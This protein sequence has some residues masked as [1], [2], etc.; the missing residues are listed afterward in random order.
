MEPEYTDVVLLK[1]E[2]GTRCATKI[3]LNRTETA[4][5]RVGEKF[6]EVSPSLATIIIYIIR[7]G[8]RLDVWFDG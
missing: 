6:H 1:L 2:N 8:L 3:V 4:A 5:T 7:C